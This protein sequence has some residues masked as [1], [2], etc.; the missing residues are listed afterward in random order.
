LIENGVNGLLVKPDD[1]EQ[2]AG[3]IKALLT[4]KVRAEMIGKA[5]KGHI[6]R[7]FEISET[8]QP[9]FKYFLSR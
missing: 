3:S 9:M 2:L 8:V 7:H 4:D 5:A 1:P 6:I